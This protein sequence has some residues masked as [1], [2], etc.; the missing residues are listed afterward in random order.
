MTFK[1]HVWGD[2]F[3]SSGLGEEKLSRESYE[4]NERSWLCEIKQNDGWES[5]TIRAK[6]LRAECIR[7][8]VLRPQHRGQ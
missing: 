3:L 4:E 2:T 7:E 1:D 5:C 6:Y 8:S